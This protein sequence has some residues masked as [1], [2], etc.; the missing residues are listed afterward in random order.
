[1]GWPEFEKWLLMIIKQWKEQKQVVIKHRAKIY[2]ETL[3]F[4]LN[5]ERE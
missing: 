4:A 5:I 3:Y 1:M 2:T